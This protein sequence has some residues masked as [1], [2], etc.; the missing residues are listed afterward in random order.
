MGCSY[1]Y[2][3]ELVLN[4]VHACFKLGKNNRR[5]SGKK[6]GGRLGAIQTNSRTR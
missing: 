6:D 3:N 5:R 1:W 2:K 4:F